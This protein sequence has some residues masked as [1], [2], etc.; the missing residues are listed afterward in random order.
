MK[1]KRI[2]LGFLTLSITLCLATAA[3]QAQSRFIANG[4]TTTPKAAPP[5]ATVDGKFEIDSATQGNNDSGSGVVGFT[6]LNRKIGDKR[7]RHGD[8]AENKEKSEHH[9][10]VETTFDGLNFYDQRFAN[11]GNQFSLEPPDQGLCAGNGFVLESVNDVLRV[12]DTAGNPL[13][14]VVDLNTFYGYPAAINRSASPLTFGPSITDPSCYFDQDTQRWFQVAL[15]LDRA[16][17]TTENLSGKNHLDLAVSKTS[18]P[19]GEWTIY[20]IPV[21][22]DGTDGTPNH[23]CSL[24]PSQGTTGPCLG[25]YPHIGADAYGIYLTTNEF[26]LFGPGFYGAQIYALPKMALTSAAA[27][28]HVFQ[29]NTGAANFA[30]A[31]GLPGFTVIPAISPGHTESEG[32]GTEYFLSSTAVFS[33]TGVDSRVQLW[34][35]GDTHNL[36]AGTAPTLLNSSVPSESYGIPNFARQ[37][38]AGTNGIGM[39]PGGGNVDWPLGQ[40]LNEPTC[41]P[42]LLGVADP[43]TEVISPLAGDDSRMTQVYFADGKVWGSLGTGV[44]F[45]GQTFGADGIAYFIVKPHSDHNGLSGRVLK[46]GYVATAGADLTYPTFG[47]AST[48]NAILSFTLTGPNDFPSLAYVNLNQA[49]GAGPIHMAAHGIGAQDGFTGYQALDGSPTDP[50]WGDFGSTAVV[51]TEIF[52]GQEYIGQS[53]SLTEFI[54]SSPFGSCNATRGAF[55]NWGTRILRLSTNVGED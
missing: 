37:P 45:D 49:K 51:G 42:A 25:D 35:L 5:A 6:K 12:F 38:G 27:M 33:N 4:G 34:A 43:Y 3:A 30:S 29:Y 41:A 28:V 55:G 26:S 16:A 47:V 2:G 24:N 44:S 39:K 13:I 32:Q 20:R 7:G 54:T 50:R 17:P 21:Q 9:K 23:G 1:S 40:C 15:T 52:A 18:N 48:G 14:G 19:L 11:Y 36:A 8:R 31:T 53:C 10:A 46:Q 22:D